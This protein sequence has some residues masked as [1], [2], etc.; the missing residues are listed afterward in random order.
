MYIK[1]FI[2]AL[3]FSSVSAQA[4]PAYLSALD[5]VIGAPPFSITYNLDGGELPEGEMNPAS[6]TIESA[7]IT[8]VNPVRTGY[9][10]AGWTG[11]YIVEPTIT[12]TIAAG[13]TGERSY[14]ATWTVNQYT[15]TFDSN[16]G[17]EV[18]PITQDYG[19]P[20]TAPENPTRADYIFVGWDREISAS[21]P[22][23]NITIRANW[24]F[25][26]H[27]NEPEPYIEPNDPEIPN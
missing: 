26:G 24:E 13:S 21:M 27:E 8:L 4:E 15:I 11:T 22:A 2:V 16:G 18:A 5:Q 25:V 12:V 19:T 7:D 23:E 1:E 6:Y 3:L 9:T 10:F 20:I 14:T 17:S